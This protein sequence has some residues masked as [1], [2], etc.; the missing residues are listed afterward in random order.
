MKKPALAAAA[1]AAFATSGCAAL[2]GAGAGA[3]AVTCA[4]DDV[5]CVEEVENEAEDVADDI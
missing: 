5:D 3:A 1:L 2:L 4:P